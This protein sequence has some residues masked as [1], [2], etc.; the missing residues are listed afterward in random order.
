MLYSIY[1]H[2]ILRA[3]IGVVEAVVFKLLIYRINYYINSGLE[4]NAIKVVIYRQCYNLL[5]KHNTVDYLIL[6]D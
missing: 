4:R 6:S 3:T 1:R 2:I 5:Q